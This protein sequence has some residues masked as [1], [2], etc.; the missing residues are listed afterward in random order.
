MNNNFTSKYPMGS[1]KGYSVSLRSSS[2]NLPALP[3]NGGK[4][5]P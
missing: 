5:R 4:N 3:L 2:K 1:V